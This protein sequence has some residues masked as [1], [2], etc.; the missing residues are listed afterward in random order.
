[1][2]KEKRII[3]S[4]EM[5]N[6]IKFVKKMTKTMV[7][8]SDMEKMNWV[9]ARKRNNLFYLIMPKQK[10][11]KFDKVN[12]G[13]VRALCSEFNKCDDKNII[14]YLH[15]G[16][17]V[18]GSAFVSKAYSS[19]LAKYSGYKVYAPEYALSPEN[20]YPEGFND[21]CQAFEE[22]S[23]IYPDAK[24]SLV[25]ESAGGNYCLA[26]GLKYKSTGKIASVTVHS[27]T[28]D[29]TGVVDH[30]INENKDFIVKLGCNEP[31]KRMYV[32]NHDASDPFVSPIMGDF[33]GFPPVFLT[34]DCNE[35]LYADSKALYEKCIQSG[36]EISMIEVEGAYHAFAV[37]G[38]STPE[39]KQI[40]DENMEFIKKY[41][42]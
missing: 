41:S 15:G 4:K 11:V 18:T 38:T 26:L 34:C 42:K 36:V 33:T 23:R 6:V 39:T 19:T 7:F 21:C 8:D 2:L 13:K 25:G 40:L 10:G 31:L 22:L 28:V 3:N 16:G 35:T 37:S 14:I 17:F 20:K 29:F 1:M 12:L 32:G 9:K 5:K 24:F 30:K 27:P